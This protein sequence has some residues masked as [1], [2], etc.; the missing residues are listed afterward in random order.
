ML[1]AA[2]GAIVAGSAIVR[3]GT[4][5]TLCLRV[6]QATDLLVDVTGWV[7]GTDGALTDVGTPVRLVDTRTGEPQLAAS[8]QAPMAA[9]E[10]R[11]IALDGV[12][13]VDATTHAV[14]INLTALSPAVAG[15]LTVSP[16]VC[17]TAVPTTSTLNVVAG[18]AISAATTVGVADG[19]ICVYSSVATD[20]AV[21]LQA[22]HGDVGG[23]L[24]VAAPIRLADTRGAT[25]V[26]PDH[27]LQIDPAAPP[28]GAVVTL[29]TLPVGAVLSVVAVNPAA[30]TTV[31]VGPCAATA[32]AAQLLVAAGTT[33]A[34]RITVPIDE[35]VGPWCVTA[36]TPAHVVV[37][38]EAWV[39]G[40]PD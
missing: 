40:P 18:V 27:A 25:I 22:H 36:S 35:A 7:G 14:S 28:S 6:S 16:G 26:D 8:L 12:A 10:Q 33:T 15:F 11:S 3:L 13:G 24:E 20:I 23:L 34:N 21:D 30:D 32:G 37:D 5:G 31:F 39:A 29:P 4:G 17:G 19:S 38:L 9:G 1:N 2:K